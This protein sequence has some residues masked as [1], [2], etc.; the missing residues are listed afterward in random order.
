MSAE[1]A[2]AALSREQEAMNLSEVT[3]EDI[4]KVS[5][6]IALKAVVVAPLAVGVHARAETWPGFVAVRSRWR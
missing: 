2:E 1:E 5:D 3:A 4:M 6:V